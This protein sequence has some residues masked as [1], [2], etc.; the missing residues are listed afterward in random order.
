MY[1]FAAATGSNDAT[2]Q[3]LQ[4]GTSH[5]VPDKILQYLT[6]KGYNPAAVSDEYAAF[7]KTLQ[8]A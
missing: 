8:A 7:R 6:V 4:N 5:V 1:Q 3:K 2:I